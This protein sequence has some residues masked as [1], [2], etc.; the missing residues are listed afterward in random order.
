VVVPAVNITTPFTASSGGISMAAASGSVAPRLQLSGNNSYGGVTQ[1]NSGI[2]QAA[3]NTA[4]GGAGSVT[5]NGGVLELNGVNITGKSLTLT[6]GSLSDQNQTVQLGTGGT[7]AIMG[8]GALRATAGASSWTGPVTLAN[9]ANLGITVAQ[10]AS[11]DLSGQLT[12]SGDFL[13]KQG[14]CLLS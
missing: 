10:N 5:V 1:V 9:N 7:V 2:L 4:L 14:G 12:G 8:S 11:L 13:F 3:S 6:A